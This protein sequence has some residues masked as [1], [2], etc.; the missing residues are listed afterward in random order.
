MLSSVIRIST[1]VWPNRSNISKTLGVSRP[2]EST[3]SRSS[4]ASSSGRPSSVVVLPVWRASG[5]GLLVCMESSLVEICANWLAS[6]SCSDLSKT[7][8]ASWLILHLLIDR[9]RVMRLSSVRVFIPVDSCLIQCWPRINYDVC[10]SLTSWEKVVGC[11]KTPL[12]LHT[13]TPVRSIMITVITR[14]PARNTAGNVSVSLCQYTVDSLDAGY[15]QHEQEEQCFGQQDQKN[16]ASRRRCGQ[17]ISADSCSHWYGF[18]RLSS[19]PPWIPTSIRSCDWS[20]DP[21][22]LGA[23]NAWLL[24]SAYN[25]DL[26]GSAG[27]RGKCSGHNQRR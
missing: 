11:R 26:S 22:M 21:I 13:L 4:N 15:S 20:L 24:C 6:R 14:L 23:C 1:S 8:E 12:C 7:W 2:R 19:L 25:G 10:K 18:L 5:L 27:K 17:D 16:D 9:A 3:N